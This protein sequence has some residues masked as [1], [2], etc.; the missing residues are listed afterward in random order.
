MTPFYFTV[1][2]PVSIG[3]DIFTSGDLHHNWADVGMREFYSC[4]LCALSHCC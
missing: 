3:C 1:L 4:S 2:R